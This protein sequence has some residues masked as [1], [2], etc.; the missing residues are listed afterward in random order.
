MRPRIALATLLSLVLAL[1]V[2][3]QQKKEELVDQVKSAIEAGCR[4][5]RQ[6]Q[7]GQGSWERV[8]IVGRGMIFEPAGQTC[9]A[10]LALLNAGEKPSSNVIQSGLACIRNIQPRQ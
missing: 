7:D 4:Y 9:L 1:P 10:V 8:G 5:L 3:A 2:C 6:Q